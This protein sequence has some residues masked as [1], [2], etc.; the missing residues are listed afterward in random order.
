VDTNGP[1]IP[2]SGLNANEFTSELRTNVLSAVAGTIGNLGVITDTNYTLNLLSNETATVSVTLDYGDLTLIRAA[3]YGTEYGIYTLNSQNLDVQLA[4]LRSLYTNGFLSAGQVLADYPQLFT[5]ATTNDLQSACNAFTNAVNAYFSA[6]A[7]IRSRPTNEVR[8]FNYDPAMAQSEGN[9]RLVLQDLK[10]SLLLGPQTLALNPDFTVNMGALFD[11]PASWRSLLP[12]FSGNAIELGSLP[13]LTFGESIG[14]LTEEEVE[15]F[16]GRA[17]KMLPVGRAPQL[18]N[19]NELNLTFTTLL[20]HYYVLQTSSNLLNWDIVAY[21][22]AQNAT[23]TLIDQEPAGV[24]RR[25]FRLRDDAGFMAFSGVVLDQQTSLPIAGAQVLS[26]WD[27]TI[28]FTDANGRF[29]LRTSSPA[30]WG[31]GYLQVSATG[32]NP[33]SNYYYGNGLVAGLTVY[34]YPPPANDNFVNRI[35]LTGSNVATNGNNAGASWE[36]GEPP[37]DYGGYGDKSVW[38]TWTVPANGPYTVSVSTSAVYYPILSLYIGTQLSSLSTVANRIGT[39]Y[40]ASY[41]FTG[42]AGQDYQIEIDDYYG[43]G[44]PYTLSIVP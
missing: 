30:S 40:Y 24:T 43:V 19:S 26:L 22:T 32:Y 20:G 4:A 28:T 2:A 7:F 33:V 42:A 29:Y 8:L 39:S 31:V 12:T 14:G 6:S 1:V 27:G 21:F 34:L 23:T 11:D 18:S 13:D 17:F 9:F 38:F 25:F 35:V 36:S 37:D 5:F 41:A 16:L 15:S 10:N 3:L 44:G